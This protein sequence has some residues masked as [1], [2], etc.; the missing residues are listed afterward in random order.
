MQIPAANERSVD[1]MVSATYEH[2]GAEVVRSK[3]KLV[4]SKIEKAKFTIQF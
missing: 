2:A 4:N 1:V 3:L